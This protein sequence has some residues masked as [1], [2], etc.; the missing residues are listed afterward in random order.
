MNTL[1]ELGAIFSIVGIPSIFALVIYFHRK[2]IEIM[3][4]KIQLLEAEKKHMEN[5]TSDKLM[6]L[7]ERRKRAFE[8]LLSELDELSESKEKIE[9]QKDELKARVY[10]LADQIKKLKRD[11]EILEVM[12]DPRGAGIKSWRDQYQDREG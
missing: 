9:T 6:E 12:S 4:E 7:L 8:V 3:K 1:S 2:H 5:S 10:E 11:N